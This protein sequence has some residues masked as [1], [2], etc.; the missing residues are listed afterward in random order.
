V[1]REVGVLFRITRQSTQRAARAGL[2]AESVLAVLKQGSKS[3]LPVNVV[4]E[5][6][7]WMSA[8]TEA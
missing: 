5:I 6:N 4:H 2:T 3:P 1:G 7:G 8:P